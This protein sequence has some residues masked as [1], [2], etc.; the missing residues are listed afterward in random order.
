MGTQV[1]GAGVSNV[2]YDVRQYRADDLEA[3]LELHEAVFGKGRD[4]EWFAWKYEDNPYVY[5]VPILVVEQDGDLVG[6]RPFFALELC[7]N[8]DRHVALQPGDTMVHPDHRR[9]GVFTRMNEVAIER[10]RDRD[11]SFFFNFPNEKSGAGYLKLGWER[12]TERPTYYRVHDAAALQGSAAGRAASLATRGLQLFLAGYNRLS[13]RRLDAPDDVTVQRYDSIPA[14]TLAGIEYDRRRSGIHVHRDVRFYDWRFG[15]PAW[16]YTAYVGE[17]EGEPIAGVVVGK[18][19]DDATVARVTD[20]TPLPRGA[21]ADGV[22]AL[23]KRVVE[24]HADAD[25]LAAPPVLPAALASRAGFRRDDRPPL[26]AVGS[27]TTHVVRRLGRGTEVDG[28]DVT[29]PD[30]WQL[31]FAERD[32]S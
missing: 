15:N 8:G 12:V 3:F 31:S 27:T 20:V 19:T 23:L 25:L 6:A 16:E 26:S 11:V 24:A 5:H 13:S 4:R 14:E 30:N 10:Y 2:E 7:V 18:S 21:A 32:T 22:E 29:D 9:Q 28:V 1:D 17:S